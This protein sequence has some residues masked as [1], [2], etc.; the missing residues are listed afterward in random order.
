MVRRECRTCNLKVPNRNYSRP[1]PIT[2][3]LQTLRPKAFLLIAI[4]FDREQPSNGETRSNAH[5]KA[6]INGHQESN[7]VYWRFANCALFEFWVIFL[8]W[9]ELCVD[10]T[11]QVETFP[12]VEV[13]SCLVA[14]CDLQDP[15]RLPEM[16]SQPGLWTIELL[17]AFKARTARVL[18]LIV[19]ENLK[20]PSSHAWAHV[21]TG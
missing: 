12:C 9:P 18:K 3:T 14:F 10:A 21:E 2:S 16:V 8:F 15:F 11:D 19:F 5:K 4:L 20:Q 6:V 17:K 7:R 13:L 1:N